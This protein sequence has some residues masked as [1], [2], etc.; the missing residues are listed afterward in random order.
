MKG[1]L[2]TPRG[3][4]DKT[5]HSSFDSAVAHMLKDEG[6]KTLTAF[7]ES[8]EEDTIDYAIELTETS[9]YIDDGPYIDEVE[10]RLS[11]V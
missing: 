3:Y 6:F 7:I 1:Y 5:V 11:N 4:S 8:I 2:Y 10:L 9:L